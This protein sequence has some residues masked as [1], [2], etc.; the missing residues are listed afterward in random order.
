M[1]REAMKLT[2]ELQGRND[3]LHF[4]KMARTASCEGRQNSQAR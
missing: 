2:K 3:T 1:E 4:R